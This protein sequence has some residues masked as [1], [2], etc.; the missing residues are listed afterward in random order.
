MKENAALMGGEQSSHICFADRWFGFD[1]ALYAAARILPL[2]PTLDTLNQALPSYPSTPELR[3]PINEEQKWNVVPRI[4]PKLN[5]YTLNETD[6]IH[7]S[8]EDGWALIRPSNTEAC[9]SLRIEA[10]TTESLQRFAQ[11][12]NTELMTL[13]VATQALREFL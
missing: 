4:K 9:I 13:G 10:K 3:L 2:I 5:D 7:L 6:G 1:D 11:H 12:L 8:N